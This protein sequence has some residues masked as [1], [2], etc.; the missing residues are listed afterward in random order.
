MDWL[1]DNYVMRQFVRPAL[2]ILLLSFLVYKSWN[3]LVQT[4]A[5]Q[6]VKGAAIMVLIY[7]LA[8]FLGLDTLLLILNLLFPGIVIA[9]A[10][11]F[12]PELRKIFTRIGQGEWLRFSPRTRA[13][14]LESILNS[15]EVMS[16]KRQGCLIVFTRTTGLKSIIET[17]TRVNADLSASLLLTIFAHGTPLHDGAT[18]SYTHLTLPT[19]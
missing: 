12:Q 15:V 18:V 19:N 4:R 1:T 13:Y 2:D 11:I 6:V 10:I 5:V 17:G 14:H 9:I 7:I 3:I 8:F 16:S